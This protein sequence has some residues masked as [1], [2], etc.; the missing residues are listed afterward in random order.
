LLGGIVLYLPLSM[1]SG[2]YSMPAVWGLD[3]L[4]A[5][6][7]SALV[8]LPVTVWKKAAWAAVCAGVAV[9]AVANVGRQEKFAARAKMLWAAIHHVEATAPPS[10]RIAWMSGDSLR[11]GLN[12]EEG[13]HFQ[14]HLYHRG[15]G[16]IR[17]GLF[18]EAGKP[19]D[20]VELPPLDGAVT[21]ALMGRGAA[22]P[23]GWEPEQ[24]FAGTY[25]L[26]RKRYDCQL[27]R[28]RLPA[29]HAGAEQRNE[30]GKIFHAMLGN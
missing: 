20:R 4:F 9:V 16:D 8:A 10:T 25:W 28:K 22:E 11:G 13:I 21:Y 7:L 14:W 19:L 29:L 6:L 12:V 18:D 27:S 15:R 3:I 24:T 1:I 23:A 30:I 2:R 5:V 26:G 17:I